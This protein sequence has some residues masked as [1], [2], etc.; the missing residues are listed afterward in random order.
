MSIA[1]HTSYNIAGNIV[2]ILIA[3][4]TIP[5][6]LKI[7]GDARFGLL[8]IAFL[9]LG[10][11]GIFD[12]GLGRAVAH[13]VAG[14]ATES[15][16]TQRRIVSTAIACNLVVG[17]IGGAL[18]WL[19]S[20][21]YFKDFLSASET[22]RSQMIAA[23]PALVLSVPITALTGVLSGA[24]EGRLQFGAMNIATMVASTLFHVLPLATAA[25]VTVDLDW[26]IAAAVLARLI[27]VGIL[28]VVCLQCFGL[29]FGFDRSRAKRLMQFGG[30]VAISSLVGPLMMIT[31]RFV[32]GAM[33]GPV[34]VAL[35]TIPFEIAARTATV[36]QSLSRALFPQ[37]SR[38]VEGLDADQMGTSVALA[39]AVIMTLLIGVG[40]VVMGPF[41][42]LW[43]DTVEPQSITVGQILLAAF[44]VNA[45]SYV[46][47]T[48]LLARGQPQIVAK[49]HCLELIPYFVILYGLTAA[50][51]VEGAA[52]AFL[53]RCM[54]DYIL[55]GHKSGLLHS[56]WLRDIGF[57]AI[58]AG[59]LVLALHYQPDA[60]TA[61]ALALFVAAAS[62]GLSFA[63]GRTQ[64]RALWLSLRSR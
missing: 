55:L 23:I 56:G 25:W 37:I 62:L 31:D 15:D 54:A 21:I 1:R 7:I 40:I 20:Y 30:W 14:A 6:Y 11:F 61:L 50:W 60:V 29:D 45:M 51:G 63:I 26:L 64:A 22:L 2:P 53:L 47:L 12:L 9:I 5:L 48:V 58:I 49:I 27:G 38:S 28:G 16:A 41:L 8:S 39:L 36:P 59:A 52:T 57:A 19:F 46:P 10:Y 4:I 44:W 18:L 3:L 42:R 24:L 34:A 43:L 13:S 33:L 17:L 35:Y 32:I